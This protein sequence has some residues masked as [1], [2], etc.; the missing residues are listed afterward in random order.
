VDLLI[1]LIIGIAA[2]VVAGALVMAA[3]GIGANHIDPVSGLGGLWLSRRINAARRRRSIKRL[4][5]DVPT[6]PPAP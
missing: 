2:L 3:L 4:P 5:P 6:P 1:S